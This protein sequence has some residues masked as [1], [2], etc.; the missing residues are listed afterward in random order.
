[1]LHVSTVVEAIGYR[2]IRDCE[3]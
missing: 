1:M 2:R 3:S